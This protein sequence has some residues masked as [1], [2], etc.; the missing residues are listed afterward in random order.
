V[1]VHVVLRQPQL[2]G[3]GQPD[4]SGQC[5]NYFRVRLLLRPAHQHA[6]SGQPGPPLRRE[7]AGEPPPTRGQ[8]GTGG[9]YRKQPRCAGVTG[10]L[11]VAQC[12]RSYIYDSQDSKHGRGVWDSQLEVEVWRGRLFEL[13]EVHDLAVDHVLHERRRLREATLDGAPRRELPLEADDVPVLQ[14][15]TSARQQQG[16]SGGRGPRRDRRKDGCSN[17]GSRQEL[18]PCI[19]ITHEAAFLAHLAAL[20]GELLVDRLAHDGGVELDLLK[21][22]DGLALWEACQLVDPPHN[23]RGPAS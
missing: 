9:D 1:R 4:P 6:A 22:L 3:V 21:E 8:D 7:S 11:P 12:Y 17:K 13:S 16:R 5:G 2:G 15:D 19:R 18:G 23:L 14:L 10:A 20:K